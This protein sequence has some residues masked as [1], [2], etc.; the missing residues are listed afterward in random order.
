MKLEFTVAAALAALAFALPLHAESTVLR[1]C[2]L[3][4]VANSNALQKVDPA[5]VF[6]GTLPGSRVYQEGESPLNP[7]D[8]NPATDITVTVQDN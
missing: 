4:A 7:G 3:K 6:T 1:G 8:G 5:C 2:E